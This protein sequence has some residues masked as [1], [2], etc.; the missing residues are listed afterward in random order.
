VVV[1]TVSPPVGSAVVILVNV[2]KQV[3]TGSQ[4]MLNK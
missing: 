3:I 1:N 2:F 4:T